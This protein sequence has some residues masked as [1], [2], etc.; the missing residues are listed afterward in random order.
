MYLEKPL[1]LIV[2]PL[3]YA[4]KSVKRYG[5][6]ILVVLLLKALILT[7]LH[8][9]YELLISPVTRAYVILTSHLREL[10][11]VECRKSAN[12]AK[13]PAFK[14]TRRYGKSML[15]LKTSLPTVSYCACIHLKLKK[16]CILRASGPREK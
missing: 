4:S 1:K 7:V 2:K 15:L 11:W 12:G 13:R 3:P 6:G 5:N 14:P 8:Y 9:A 16:R 10:H